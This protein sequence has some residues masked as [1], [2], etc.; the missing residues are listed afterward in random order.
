MPLPGIIFGMLNKKARKTRYIP[1]QH[2]TPVKKKT[3]EKKDSC[4]G[5]NELD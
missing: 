3:V 2:C 1:Q 5:L 4:S